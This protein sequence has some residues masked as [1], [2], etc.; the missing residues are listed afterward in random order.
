MS[1]LGV[2]IVSMVLL[3]GVAGAAIVSVAFYL[4]D[5]KAGRHDKRS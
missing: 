5:R 4:I 2:T 1:E 3:V